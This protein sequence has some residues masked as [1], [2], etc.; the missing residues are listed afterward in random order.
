MAAK[1]TNIAIAERY[2]DSAYY[3]NIKRNY[4]K[5]LSYANICRHYLNKY[6]QSKYINGKDTMKYIGSETIPAEIEWFRSHL[7][8]S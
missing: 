6:Y 8:T 5:T 7:K 3:S 4:V 1:D 2:A